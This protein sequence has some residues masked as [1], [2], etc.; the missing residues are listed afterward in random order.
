MHTEIL[1][2]EQDE[3]EFA[4]GAEDVRAF[5]IDRALEGVVG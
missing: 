3:S 4:V 2:R 1:S 5:L